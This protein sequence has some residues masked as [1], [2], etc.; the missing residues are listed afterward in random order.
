LR[1]VLVWIWAVVLLS[2]F[3]SCSYYLV[4]SV[5]VVTSAVIH[6]PAVLHDD[7]THLEVSRLEE[8]LEDIAAMLMLFTIMWGC[9]GLVWYAALR[10]SDS[11]FRGSHILTGWPF[12]D[13]RESVREKMNAKH[14]VI[15]IAVLFSP[16]LAGCTVSQNRD[17]VCVQEDADILCYPRNAPPRQTPERGRYF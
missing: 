4:I 10:Y 8:E 1:K 5:G 13:V 15:F 6:D 14:A 16:C 17:I 7:A 11:R 9:S 3:A 2:G 12:S